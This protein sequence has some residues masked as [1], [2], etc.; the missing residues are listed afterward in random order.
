MREKAQFVSSGFLGKKVPAGFPD[1]S[2]MDESPLALAPD[3]AKLLLA[4]G[5]PTLLSSPQ[6]SLDSRHPD[7]TI[8]YS[9]KF[10]K[11]YPH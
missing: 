7:P 2:S 9:K 11:T 10:L 5:V 3:A 4:W 6:I 1:L 8:I